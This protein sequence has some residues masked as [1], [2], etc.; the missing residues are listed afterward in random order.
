[1]SF[2]PHPR[3]FFK[4]KRKFNIYTKSDNKLKFLKDFGIDIYIEFKFDKNLIRIICNQ[5][6]RKYSIDKLNIKNVVVGSKILNLEKIDWVILKY[7]KIIRKIIILMY[8]LLV[9][10]GIK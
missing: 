2:D 10:N 8:I 7:Y 3:S 5:F 6:V 1:M 4:I 9:N